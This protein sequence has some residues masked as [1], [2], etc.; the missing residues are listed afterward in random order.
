MNKLYYLIISQLREIFLFSKT[1][2]EYEQ[3]PFK[4]EPNSYAMKETPSKKI[5]QIRHYGNDGYVDCDYDFDHHG[6]PESHPYHRHNGAHKHICEPDERINETYHGTRM[7][8]TDE[9]YVKY[10]LNYRKLKAKIIPVKYIKN[11]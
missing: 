11:K 2:D 10:I 3:L 7:E 6:Y 4:G 1:Y 9:E 5:I 8:L